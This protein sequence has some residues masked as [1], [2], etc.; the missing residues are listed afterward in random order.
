MD[1]ENGRM[2]ADTLVLTGPQIVADQPVFTGL[3]LESLTIEAPNGA[4]RA[5]S[6]SLSDPSPRLAEAVAGVLRG[7][8]DLDALSELQTGYGF[9]GLDLVAPVMQINDAPELSVSLSADSVRLSDFVQDERLGL[10]EFANY[11]MEGVDE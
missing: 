7:D 8:T 4:M 3:D 10:V 9:S 5:A 6:L 2:R 11:A 1:L